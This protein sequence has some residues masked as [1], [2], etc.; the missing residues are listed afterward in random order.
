[1][2]IDFELI[3]PNG[4][5]Y[6]CEEAVSVTVPAIEGDMTV[7]KQHIPLVTELHSGMITL[8]TSHTFFQFFV[9]GGF[10]HVTRSGVYVLAK[11]AAKI[12]EHIDLVQEIL[13]EAKKMLEVSEGLIDSDRDV[14]RRYIANTENFL[15]K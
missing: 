6:T 12:G 11:K 8:N 7:Y 3:L 10:L 4:K 14:I 9:S 5:F 1:M 2:A 15:K 13:V